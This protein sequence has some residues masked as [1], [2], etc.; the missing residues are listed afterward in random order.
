MS[1]IHEL[2]I[3]WLNKSRGTVSPSRD[4]VCKLLAAL[5]GLEPLLREHPLATVPERGTS[6]LL[7]DSPGASVTG[8]DQQTAC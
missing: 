2:L 1:E 8:C 5:H 3:S 6:T 7:H 4:A